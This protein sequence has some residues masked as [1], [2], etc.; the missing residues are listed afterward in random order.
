M[1]LV[2]LDPPY[3]IGVFQ[4]W[5]KPQYI[6]WFSQVFHE[7]R[8]IAQDNVVV[9]ASQY[10]VFDI[11]ASIGIPRRQIIWYYENGKS[12][13]VNE[14]VTM[15]ECLLWYGKTYNIVREP[16]KSV[17]RIK[18][19]VWK[20]GKAWHPHS[21]GRKAGDVWAIPVLAGA[22]FAEEKVGHPTQKPKALLNR[23]IKGFSTQSVG[24]FFMGS[25]T[26]AVEARAIGRHF[27]G[28]DINPEYVEMAR[29]RLSTAQLVMEW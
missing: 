12:R 25:G 29:K 16:Y 9:F 13:Q 28:C 21:E 8:R 15:Y 26:S 7:A 11:V 23:I 2:V 18:T 1:D 20:D 24:D 10:W 17:E 4:D 22:R 27:F 6:K 19:P 5:P 3:N 14:P